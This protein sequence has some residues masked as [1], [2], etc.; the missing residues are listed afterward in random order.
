VVDV[1]WAG[2]TYRSSVAMKA[3]AEKF[4][5]TGQALQQAG[6]ELHVYG[7]GLLQAMWNT[8][9]DSLP[10]RDKYRLL[11]QFDS[12]RDYSPGEEAAGLF[13]D[14][15]KPD[16]L[17]IDFGCGTGR[18][19][20]K[21]AQAGVPVMLVD[22]ADNCRD[23]E[24]QMLP[25]LE[26]DLAQPIPLSAPYGYCTDVMEHIP[27]GD[28]DAV[29]ANIMASAQT[30]FF[31]IATREDELGA[32]IHQTLHHTVWPHEQWAERLRRLGTI[33]WQE[34]APGVSR[35]ILTRPLRKDH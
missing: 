14:R 31:Q 32:V 25:F 33:G 15:V 13:L 18:G 10:E 28:V 11:W 21:I 29:L 34:N 12:Y 9:R 7:N 17:V 20:V 4:Q 16:G 35:F 19:A 2:K 24:A 22:F 26:W 8:P 23:E 30:V 5:V 3:Q 1:E 6:C 27:T